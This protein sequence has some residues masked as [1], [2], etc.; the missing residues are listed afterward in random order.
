M[1]RTTAA[2]LTLSL[3]TLSQGAC[4]LEEDGN[5]EDISAVDS[6]LAGGKDPII[7]VPGC[8]PPP[9]TNEDGFFLFIPMTQYFLSKGYPESYLNT[10]VFSGLCGSNITQAA[11]LGALVQQVRAATGAPRVDIVAHSM[12]ALTVRYYLSQG[13]NRYVRDF[14]MVGGANHGSELGY[15][16]PD[17]QE[18]FGAPAYEGLKEMGPPYACAGES[19]G[20]DVQATV[21]GCLTLTGRTVKVDETP[22]AGTDY[23][24][25]RNTVDEF[26]VPAESA[27]LNQR[28]M[29]DC[30]DL[31]VNVQVNVPPGLCPDGSPCTGHEMMLFDAGVLNRIYNFVAQPD[32]GNDTVGGTGDDDND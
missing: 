18:I 22:N 20:A 5:D 29:N 32:D 10:I 15:L 26:V 7:F 16:G 27:C 17:L 3:F 12:G 14:V 6:E 24:S 31:A 9:Y 8:P 25:I 30:G 2:A 19:F 23:L 1:W 13:G 21:N 28:F 11:E 4:V